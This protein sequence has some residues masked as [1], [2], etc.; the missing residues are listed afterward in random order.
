M[1]S[2]EEYLDD[3]LKSIAEDEGESE[4][5]DTE[6]GET[7]SLDDLGLAIEDTDNLADAVEG[8]ADVESA[9]GVAEDVPLDDFALE[10]FGEEEPFENLEPEEAEPE[11][12]VD[13]EKMVDFALE[14][15]I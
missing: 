1:S 5:L 6:S 2:D 15:F 13:K 10:D 12:P 3:L 7:P 11:S 14:E 8:G 4:H 9:D